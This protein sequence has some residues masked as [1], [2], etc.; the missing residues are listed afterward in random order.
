[1]AKITPVSKLLLTPGPGVS[2]PPSGVRRGDGP[3][4]KR[5]RRTSI[6]GDELTMLQKCFEANQR[7]TPKEFDL[8]ATEFKLDREVV[9]V[10]FANKRAKFRKSSPNAIDN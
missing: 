10:W 3:G 8:M 4:V 5:K 6:G 9:R 1:M 2:A 7:P